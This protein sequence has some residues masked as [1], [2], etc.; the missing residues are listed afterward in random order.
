MC[1]KGRI[2]HRE[3][4]KA[5][6]EMSEVEF[7]SFLRRFL[8]GASE[9]LADGSLSYVCIDWRHLG[10]LLSAARSAELELLNLCIWVK[11]NGGMGSL[12]RS[13]HELVFV[14]KTDRGRHLNNVQLGRFGRNRTNVWEFPRV[15]TLD[16][17][18]RS[19]LEI[20]PTVKPVEMVTDAI[21]DASRPGDIVLD[22]F[23]G[24]GTTAIAAEKARRTCY[25][26]EL[27]PLYV[28]AAIRRWETFSG[29]AALD[30]ETEHTFAEVSQKRSTSSRPPASLPSS[31][32][33]D[34][35]GQLSL[36]AEMDEG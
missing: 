23:L 30:A 20:H 18:R 32:P 35:D 16:P 12:Y 27:D 21:L 1:G 24:S 3:F 11:P 7:T 34:D 9:C 5:S 13:R 28:D 33:V 8:R 31:V 36:F 10:E 22:P 19:D 14:L 15:N 2:R 25:G 26:I 17:E 4:V 29:E 6:G